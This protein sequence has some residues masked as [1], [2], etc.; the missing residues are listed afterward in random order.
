MSTATENFE[1]LVTET[2]KAEKPEW[3]QITREVFDK[4]IAMGKDE[5]LA[6][7]P[8]LSDEQVSKGLKYVSDRF[9]ERV[10]QKK[11][12]VFPVRREKQGAAGKLYLG[13][14]GRLNKALTEEQSKR[15][16]SNAF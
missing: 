16:A 6:R 11:Y 5:F 10:P 4:V 1:D 3:V 12:L 14:L 9:A 2:P 7:I 15:L 8:G 13:S